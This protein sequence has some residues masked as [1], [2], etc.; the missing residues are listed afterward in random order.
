MTVESVGL[1]VTSGS[2]TQPPSSCNDQSNPSYISNQPTTY[3]TPPSDPKTTGKWNGYQARRATLSNRWTGH[4][5][6]SLSR[7]IN[8]SYSVVSESYTQLPTT[9]TTTSSSSIPSAIGKGPANAPRSTDPLAPVKSESVPDFFYPIYLVLLVALIWVLIPF[10]PILSHIQVL[11]HRYGGVYLSTMVTLSLSVFAGGLALWHRPTLLAFYTRIKESPAFPSLQRIAW[12]LGSTLAISRMLPL[13]FT[14]LHVVCIQM[15]VAGPLAIFLGLLI[16]SLMIGILCLCLLLRV[17]WRVSDHLYHSLCWVLSIEPTSSTKEAPT[18]HEMLLGAT[19]STLTPN[20][21]ND[22]TGGGTDYVAGSTF[23]ARRHSTLLYDPTA[24][25]FPRLAG[26][27]D[28]STRNREDR[29]G[30]NPTTLRHEP[31]IDLKR[32]KPNRFSS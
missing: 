32:F 12:V 31:K 9:T 10:F 13:A 28:A 5:D 18:R 26:V 21:D 6:S 11:A 20:P 15:H 22:N 14:W 2:K 29:T 4:P 7:P 1:T 23:Y 3:R 16:W 25:V 19:T 27:F 17:S 30:S 24:V 8:S